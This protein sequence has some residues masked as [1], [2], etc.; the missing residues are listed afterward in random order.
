MDKLCLHTI[1]TK[2]LSF[3]QALQRYSEKGIPAISIWQNAILEIGPKRARKLLDNYQLEVVSYVRGGFFPNINADLRKQAITNNK[4]MLREAAEIGAPLLVLVCGA[5][6]KQS[7]STSR[8]QIKEG[9]ERLLPTAES[10]GVRLGLEPLHP[11]YAH[12]RSAINTM[13]QANDFTDEIRH[14]LLGIVVDVFHLWWEENLR[15][16]IMHAGQH[17]KLFAYHICDWKMPMND[18][19]NDR[20]LMGDGCINLAEIGQWMK[21]AGFNGYHEVEIFS[22]HYWSMD[23]NKFLNKIIERYNA[24]K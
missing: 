18:L 24:I 1:T 22:N 8:E 9:I 10:M 16:E 6:P 2:P 15:S 3:E 13:K 20:G 19:L 7:L 21:E 11:M 5:D 17:K 14:D 23:Q 4:I 12:S